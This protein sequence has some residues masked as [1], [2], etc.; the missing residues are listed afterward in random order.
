VNDLAFARR[1]YG[2]LTANNQAQR[3]RFLF[4]WELA[5][6]APLLFTAA[7]HPGAVLTGAQARQPWWIRGLVHTVARPGFV[8]AEVGAIPVLRLAA[9]PGVADQ[10]GRF[11]DGPRPSAD[12]PDPEMALQFWRAC[13]SMTIVHPAGN[14]VA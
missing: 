10:S 13:E 7:V 12:M 6:R 1:A 5:R 3:G 4:M 2:W 11:F 14:Q 9:H 8:R